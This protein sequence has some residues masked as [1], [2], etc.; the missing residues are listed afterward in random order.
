MGAEHAPI[1]ADVKRQVA[2]YFDALEAGGLTDADVA[3]GAPRKHR[4]RKKLLLAL[5]LPF[6]IPGAL[7]YFVPYQI[8]RIVGMRAR[9]KEDDVV[10]TYKL[11]TGLVVFPLWAGALVGAS[12]TLLPPPLSIGAAA[13][14]IASPFAA[15]AWLDYLDARR[16]GRRAEPSDI[17]R[18]G[19]LRAELVALLSRARE[20]LVPATTN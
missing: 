8:P 20:A 1:Y 14:A 15:L 3:T 19:A 12:F 11:A 10:S 17:A 16:L 6:A 5:A 4:K 13:V 2:R 9:G 18:I 7:L